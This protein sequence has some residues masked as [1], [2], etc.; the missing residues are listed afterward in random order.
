MLAPPSKFIYTKCWFLSQWFPFPI[1]ASEAPVLLHSNL[2]FLDRHMITS[3]HAGMF[4]KKA[5]IV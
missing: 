4:P 3:I 5:G 2:I 1:G